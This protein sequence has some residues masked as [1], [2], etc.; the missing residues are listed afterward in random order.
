M[1]I[2]KIGVLGCGLMGSGI[3]EVA[4]KAGFDT[5]VREVSDVLLEKGMG[6]IRGSLGKAVE[7]GKMTA[8]ERD[9]VLGRI[10]GTTGFEAMADCDLVVEAIVENLEEKKAPASSRTS[11]A[12]TSTSAWPSC[13]SKRA[14]AKSSPHRLSALK[15]AVAACRF[16][17]A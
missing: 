12:K 14:K 2:R 7:K 15:S 10:H 8:E 3:A 11:R 4:A 1:A 6:K 13:S 9:A 17:A 16:P 5:V